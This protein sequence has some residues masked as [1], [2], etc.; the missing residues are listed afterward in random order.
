[1]IQTELIR[2]TLE[3]HFQDQLNTFLRTLDGI[4]RKLV[5]VQYNHTTPDTGRRSYSALVFYETDKPAEIKDPKAQKYRKVGSIEFQNLDDA[6]LAG[7]APLN[8]AT[9]N[10]ILENR[11]KFPEYIVTRAASIHEEMRRD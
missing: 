7:A 1:M 9:V 8:A 6:V 4:S 5:E 10:Y 11:E 2:D 3:E